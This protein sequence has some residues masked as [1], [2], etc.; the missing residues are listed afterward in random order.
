MACAKVMLR[1]CSK[2]FDLCQCSVECVNVVL[3]N[4][5]PYLVSNS[6]LRDKSLS[7]LNKEVHI[8]PQDK[9]RVIKPADFT[10]LLLH[11]RSE[12]KVK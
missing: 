3:E 10:C 9:E 5:D 6:E 2:P 1:F 11:S 12:S 4:G 7:K 8:E